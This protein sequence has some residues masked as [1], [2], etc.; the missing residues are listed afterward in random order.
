MPGG[1]LR[2]SLPFKA[3]NTCVFKKLC[4]LKLRKITKIEEL[5]HKSIEFCNLV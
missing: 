5:K 1:P 4:Q 2:P 3:S